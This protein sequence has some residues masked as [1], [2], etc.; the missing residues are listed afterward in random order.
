MKQDLRG[1]VLKVARLLDVPAS[2]DIIERV[3]EKSSL[4]YMK[5]ID[6]KFRMWQLIP[7]V[8]TGPMIRKGMQGGSSELLN[9]EQQRQVDDYFIAELK[10]LGSDLPYEEFCDLA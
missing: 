3:C 9:D 1:A 4:E 10:C 6:E 7:W 2:N 8:R 5:R